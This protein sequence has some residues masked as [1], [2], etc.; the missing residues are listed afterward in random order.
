MV[1]WRLPEPA[2]PC[3]HPF[4]YRLVYVVEG[5]RVIGFDNERGKGDHS[6]IE[7]EERPYCVRGHG[8][9]DRRLH[10]GGGTMEQRTL[11]V[12]VQPDWRGALR[13][14]GQAAEARHYQGE[15]LNFETPEAF[16]SHLTARRWALV[17]LLLGVGEVSVRDLARRADRDVRRVSMKT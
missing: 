10:R 4:K 15:R 16:F 2:P 1:A 6:H 3:S 8:S 12:T 5:E 9:L 17:H 11:I 13:V 14:A 7:G